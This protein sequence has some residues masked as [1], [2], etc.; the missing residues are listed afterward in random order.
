MGV[1][2]ADTRSIE[3]EL[4]S[5]LGA[6][7]TSSVAAGSGLSLLGRATGQ[8]WLTGFA[9]Q[10]V[11]WGAVDGAIASFGALR[12]RGQSPAG[13]AIIDS[14]DRPTPEAMQQAA[15][16]HTLLRVNTA[17]DVLYVAAGL[18]TIAKAEALGQRFGRSTAEC[19]GAGAGV[20]VQGGF[21]LALDAFFARRVGRFI[22]DVNV[23]TAE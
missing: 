17:L 1:V 3:R 14:S 7:A 8:T 21:L 23:A 12:Q 19:V 2:E 5:A 15:R 22:K 16:L 20:V 13:L 6:W 4:T 11:G 18:V 9:N 10:Q